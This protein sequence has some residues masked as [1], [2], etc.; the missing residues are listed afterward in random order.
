MVVHEMRNPAIAIEMALKE[1]LKTFTNSE[2]HSID[3][4]KL[5]E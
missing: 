1:V 2:A 5:D 3:S 4:F